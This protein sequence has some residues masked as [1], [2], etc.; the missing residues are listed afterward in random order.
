MIEIVAAEST[1]GGSAFTFLIFLVPIGL[2]YFMMRSNKRRLNQQQTQQRAAEVGEEILT[3]SG[4]YGTIV[5]ADDEDDT[6]LVEIAPGT[7][8]KMVRAGIARRLT[9]DEPED[10][11]EEDDEPE[12]ENEGGPIRS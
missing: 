5:Q 9:E 11:P 12:D 10:E 4:I 8:I 7:R 3:T 1:G 2:L 6:V